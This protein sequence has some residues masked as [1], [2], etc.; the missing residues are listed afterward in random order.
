MTGTEAWSTGWFLT[1]QIRKNNEAR[2]E[3][4]FCLAWYAQRHRIDIDDSERCCQHKRDP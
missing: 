1:K 2:F 3:T 4:V